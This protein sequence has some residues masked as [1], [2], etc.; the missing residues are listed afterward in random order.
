MNKRNNK[1]DIL[2]IFTESS[3]VS[4]FVAF[5]FAVVGIRCL[6]YGIMGGTSTLL[7]IAGAC[8][9]AALAYAVWKHANGLHGSNAIDNFVFDSWHDVKVLV[10]KLIHSIKS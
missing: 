3:V 8:V 4:M 1:M 5:V 6:I 7:R 2:S 10:G 9:F